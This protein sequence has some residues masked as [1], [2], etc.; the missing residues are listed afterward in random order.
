MLSYLIKRYAIVYETP[1][2]LAPALSF[3]ASDASTVMHPVRS[4]DVEGLGLK[5]AR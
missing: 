2:Q 4:Y 1:C 5:V 3:V